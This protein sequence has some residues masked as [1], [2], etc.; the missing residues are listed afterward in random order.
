MTTDKKK[1][2]FIDEWPMVILACLTL[3]LAP[4]VPEPHIFGK[5]RW[6]L[7]GGVGMQPMD[8][9]DFF[10]HATPFFLLLRLSF[11]TLRNKMSKKD[12]PS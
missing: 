5:V 8:Y 11:I 2:P 7:G 6:L 4:F 10:M 12:F 3:G 1:I 9:F